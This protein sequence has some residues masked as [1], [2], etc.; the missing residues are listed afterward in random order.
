MK[1]KNV[2]ADRAVNASDTLLIR[3]NAGVTLDNTNFQYDVSLDGGVNVGD[4]TTV[5][6]NSAHCAP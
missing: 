6:N 2:N 1:R 3:N 5:R 4:T